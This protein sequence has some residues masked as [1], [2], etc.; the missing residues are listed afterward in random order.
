MNNNGKVIRSFINEAILESSYK[1]SLTSLDDQIDAFFIKSEKYSLLKDKEKKSIDV[2]EFAENIA[3]LITNYDNLL[4]IPSVIVNKSI[5]FLKRNYSKEI[6][7]EF[8]ESLENDFN[9]ELSTLEN[10]PK[11]HYAMGAYTATK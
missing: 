11:N 5:S 9:V 2:E 4:D 10:V 1:S 8:K 3:R 6:S 7:E